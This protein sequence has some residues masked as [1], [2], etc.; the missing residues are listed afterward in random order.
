MPFDWVAETEPS[1]AVKPSW[2]RSPYAEWTGKVLKEY[3][4]AGVEY[5]VSRDNSIIGDAPGLGK[6]AQA[7][8]IGNTIEAKSTLVVC[9]ASLRGNWCR[10]IGMWSTVPRVTTYPIYKAR[11]GV[12]LEANYVV[13]SYDLL[14]NEAILGAILDSRWDHLILDEAHYLK[15]PGGNKRTHAICAEN[16]IKSVVGRITMAT[17]TLLPNQ[18]IE[19]YNAIRLVDWDAI[20][21]CSLEDF[22]ETYYDLGEGYVRKKVTR[23]DPQTHQPYT[24]YALVWSDEIRNVPRNLDDFQYRLRKHCMVRRLKEQVLHELPPKQWH[25]FP[26]AITKEMQAALRHPGWQEAEKLYQLDPDAFNAD[27]PVDGAISTARRELGEAKA[28]AVAEFV[29]DLLNGGVEKV[30]VG[31]WHHTVLDYL[32][33]RLQKYGVAFMDGRSSAKRKEIEADRF[34]DDPNCRIMLGQMLPLGLG[35]PQFVVAQ[36]AV[37]AEPY[38]VPGQNDQFLDRLHRMGQQGS[39]VIG[40]IP[41]VPGTLDEGILATAIEKDVTIFNA[42]DRH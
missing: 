1:R 23:I 7:I 2:F 34:H 16:G 17:G 25:P 27:F 3:Q 20:D 35:W 10:E 9:P 26:L 4:H 40:H 21:R 41:V 31:A 6:T 28:P 12:S 37:L 13:V 19:A 29:I 24:T 36:D 39:Y 11:D 14:R 42:L 8:C 33:E 5:S 38:Y 22:R 32:K 30:L 18:P 15:D